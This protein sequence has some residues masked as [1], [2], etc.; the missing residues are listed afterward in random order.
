LKEI[1]QRELQAHLAKG[2]ELRRAELTADRS[3]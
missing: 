2:R 1:K 3:K